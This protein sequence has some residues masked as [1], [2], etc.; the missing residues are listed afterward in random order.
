MPNSRAGAVRR[1]SPACSPS[2]RS[3]CRSLRPTPA[4]FV[5]KD[6]QQ[7]TLIRR[8]SATSTSTSGSSG[9]RRCEQDGLALSSRNPLPR[10]LTRGSLAPRC[11][12]ARRGRPTPRPWCG[13]DSRHRPVPCSTPSPRS[14]WTNLEVRCVD[15]GRPPV[16][17]RRSSPGRRPYR[18]HPLI[19]NVGVAVGTGFLERDTQPGDPAVADIY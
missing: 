10:R 15:L 18:H 7:L 14:R 9:C 4:F 2:S 1:T 12:G 6:Y 19:D 11:R 16:A 13:G 17:R 8:W 5:E 3:C